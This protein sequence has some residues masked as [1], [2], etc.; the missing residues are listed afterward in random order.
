MNEVIYLIHGFN[1][2]DGGAKTTG[3]IRPYFEKEGFD[4]REID[5][6]FFFRVRARL[7]N[8]GVARVISRLVEADSTCIGHSNGGALAWLACEYGAPFKNVILVNPA[9]D[10]DLVI[11]KHIKNI[12]VWYSPR[13]KWTWLAKFIPWSIWGA[14]GKTGYT[15]TLDKRYEQYNED[16]VFDIVKDNHSGTWKDHD[17]RKYFTEQ[18]VK[19]IRGQ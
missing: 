10:S 9:L 11:A 12:Q 5:Y 16:L 7:C 17:S 18:V 4:V 3:S 19:L 1:V 2:K 13:D 6:G 14:Q 8:R 15:G